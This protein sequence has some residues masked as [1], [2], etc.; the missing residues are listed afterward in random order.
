MPVVEVNQSGKRGVSAS[1]GGIGA[2]SR[3]QF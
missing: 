3:G 1:N 2:V